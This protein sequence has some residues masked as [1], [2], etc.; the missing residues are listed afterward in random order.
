MVEKEMSTK[1]TSDAKECNNI[2]NIMIQFFVVLHVY[3][4]AF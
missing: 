1:R 4:D 2:T 3:Y